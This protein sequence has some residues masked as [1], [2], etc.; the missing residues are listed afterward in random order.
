MKLRK[1]VERSV[2]KWS[3]VTPQGVDLEA[4][5][6]WV[7]DELLDGPEPIFLFEHARPSLAQLRI[8]DGSVRR[9]WLS[10]EASQY[11]VSQLLD[12]TQNS[13]YINNHFHHATAYRFLRH[14]DMAEGQS[15]KA[16]L[17][18]AAGFNMCSWGFDDLIPG[19]LALMCDELKKQSFYVDPVYFE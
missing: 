2:G 11:L 16:H 13:K 12:Q 19:R 5:L 15:L 3:V 4:L 18:D 14:A 8:Q 10:Q 17:S 7:G 1:P 9:Y 6:A